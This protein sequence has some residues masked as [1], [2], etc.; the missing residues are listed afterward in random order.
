MKTDRSGGEVYY[1]RERI[2]RLVTAIIVAMIL[3][4]LILPIYLL[5]HLVDGK[6]T[7]HM[8]ALCIGIL[9]SFTLLFSACLSVFTSA[10]ICER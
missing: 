3:A 5:Y 6:Q 10:Y 9:L 7:N 2:D 8:S 1:T 4:L